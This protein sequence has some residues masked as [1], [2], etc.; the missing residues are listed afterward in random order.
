MVI[1]GRRFSGKTYM[2]NYIMQNTPKYDKFFFPSGTSLDANFI[3]ELFEKI[4]N[5]L[6][7]F[8]S[9]SITPEIYQLILLK[10]EYI[11]DR[12][13]KIII[14]SNT[15]E[16]FLIAKLNAAHYQIKNVFSSNE[17]DSFNIKADKFAFARQRASQT[18]LEYAYLLLKQHNMDMKNIPQD[19]RKFTLNEQT[20]IFMLCVFDRVYLHEA[21]A[22]DIRISEIEEFIDQYSILF[23]LVDC[24][25][26]EAYGKSVRKIVHNSRSILLNLLKDLPKENVLYSV[27]TIA[28]KL[29]TYDKEQ[30]KAVMMFDTLNQLFSQDGAGYLIEFIYEGLEETLYR[31]PHFWLQRAKSIYRLSRTDK[32]KLLL[33]VG[34]A[35]KAISDS[36]CEEGKNLNLHLK[37]KFSAALIYCMLYNIENEVRQKIDYQIESIE[38]MYDV[39]FLQE[40]QY[41]P[42]SVHCDITYRETVYNNIISMCEEF[43]SPEHRSTRSDTT[44]KAT[45]VI[46]KM[47]ELRGAFNN[48]PS[49]QGAQNISTE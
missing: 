11:V 38:M 32:K 45:S 29:Y 12:K 22:M 40:Y 30:Y 27:K 47:R 33:A 14:A 18:H 36:L 7:I 44:I 13:N 10:K 35:Q 16:D 17:L 9:N 41:M 2:I 1:Q 5:S 4:E 24:E 19:I 8:D 34:Y 6:F 15:N 39:L 3:E 49:L 42:K 37:S 23:E 21:I 25:P 46:R 48:N 28:S 26:E 31:E 43:I 20:I